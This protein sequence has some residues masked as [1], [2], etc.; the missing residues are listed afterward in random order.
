MAYIETR[1][2]EL[3]YSDFEQVLRHDPEYKPS[4]AGRLLAVISATDDCKGPADQSRQLRACTWLIK[5]QAPGP[6]LAIALLER[7]VVHHNQGRKDEAA[8]DLTAVIRMPET[9]SS[10]VD[11][12][13]R[14]LNAIKG[15]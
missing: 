8:A 13:R 5:T 14:L 4:L 6:V 11:R 10:D 2:W 15:N 7:A 3:A 12:A 1:E 9:P